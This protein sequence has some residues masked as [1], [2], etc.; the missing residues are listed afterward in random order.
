MDL[1]SFG[2]IALAGAAIVAG[3]AVQGAIGFGLA[4]VS[5]P[6]LALVLPDAVPT[7]VLLL[8]LPLTSSMAV[9][10]R[11]A[12]DA[13][14]VAWVTLGRAPGTVAG[15]WL[16]KA[17]PADAFAILF[18]AGVVVAAA[19]SV[20]TPAFTPRARSSVAAGFVSG[21]MGTATALGGPAL[22]L[23]WQGRSGPRLR[24]TLALSFFLGVLMSLVGVAAAGRI[25]WWHLAVAAELLPA[26]A[27]GALASR[28]AARRLDVAWLRPA[29]LAFAAGAGVLAIVRGAL[30]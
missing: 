13:R 27:L 12:I 5:V 26:L 28:Y 1:P 23:L 30:A 15:A 22:A 20:G 18:G 29:V 21:T 2:A 10:E 3:T 14:G 6:V 19:M 4:I 17:V 9:R 7:T 11:H 16:L 25:G 8:A 24:S